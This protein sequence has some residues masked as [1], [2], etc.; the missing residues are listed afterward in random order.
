MTQRQREILICLIDSYLKTGKAPSSA[1]ISE[2]LDNKWSSATIRNELVELRRLGYITKGTKV[3]ANEPT[4]DGLALYFGLRIMESL[5]QGKATNS[6]VDIQSKSVE[7]ISLDEILRNNIQIVSEYTGSPSVGLA[8][9]R[10]FVSSVKFVRLSSKKVAV[11]VITDDG[12]VESGVANVDIVVSETQLD[13]LSGLIEQTIKGKKTSEALELISQSSFFDRPFVPIKDVLCKV[14]QNISGIPKVVYILGDNPHPETIR[15]LNTFLN[16]AQK[17]LSYVYHRI[18]WRIDMGVLFD[19]MLV[20]QSIGMFADISTQKVLG[21][22]GAFFRR[23][24]DLDR[25]MDT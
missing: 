25:I 17:N 24:N 21:F 18:L 15:E 10:P 14:L 16:T 1:Y 11:M 2:A 4:E 22:M 20:N 9:V 6:S 7:A 23:D 5:V 3:S 13:L 8:L 19:D 12:A